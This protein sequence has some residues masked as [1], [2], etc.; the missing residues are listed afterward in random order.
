FAHTAP[1]FGKR[2]MT[3]YCV[4][5]FKQLTNSY[6]RPF[7]VCQRSIEI[8]STRDLEDAVAYAKQCFAQLEGI[9]VW[10]LRASIIEARPIVAPPDFPTGSG[11]DGRDRRGGRRE[12]SATKRYRQHADDD[13]A[14]PGSQSDELADK[15]NDRRAREKSAV[16]GR[17]DRRDPE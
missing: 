7:K 8:R 14:E 16:S 9:P 3:G 2:R 17:R 15:A 12:S 4:S 11:G 13:H 6:G 10:D 5:F 1:P